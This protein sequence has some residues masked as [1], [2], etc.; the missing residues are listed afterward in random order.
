MLFD[1]DGVAFVLAQNGTID[2][3]DCSSNLSAWHLVHVIEVA[4]RPSRST[5]YHCVQMN[6]LTSATH[7]L[8]APS[9][10]SGEGS[11]GNRGVVQVDCAC[12]GSR[13]A[14]QTAN[15]LHILRPLN[16]SS[17]DPRDVWRCS[18]INIYLDHPDNDGVCGSR[19]VRGSS[20]AIC[21]TSVEV[22]D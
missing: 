10:R 12:R 8:G 1:T 17:H 15:A 19:G 5:A 2:A 16:A 13:R 14:G 11:R 7:I 18:Y 21:P 9:G 6:A 20:I 3:G 22:R 4:S